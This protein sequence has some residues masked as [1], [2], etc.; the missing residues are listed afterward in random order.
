MNEVPAEHRM[1]ESDG[2]LKKPR[3]LEECE[4]HTTVCEENLVFV[5]C[6][7]CAKEGDHEYC[8]SVHDVQLHVHFATAMKM[9]REDE[10]FRGELNN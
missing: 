7:E 2:Y 10:T 1:V 6:L 8:E 9:I 3:A 5:E 4:E